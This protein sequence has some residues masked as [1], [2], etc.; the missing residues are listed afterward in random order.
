MP[1]Q[2]VPG[3]GGPIGEEPPCDSQTESWHLQHSGARRGGARH[4]LGHSTT[5]AKHGPQRV[6]GGRDV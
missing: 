1:R 5:R 3:H 6:R 2:R 4:P